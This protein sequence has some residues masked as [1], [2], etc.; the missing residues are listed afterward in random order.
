M[1]NEK[2]ITCGKC[3]CKYFPRLKY[4]STEIVAKG[5]KTENE[6]IVDT[7]CPQCGAGSALNGQLTEEPTHKRRLLLG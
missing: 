4:F 5:H 7:S 6:C 3:T 1:L 2:Q